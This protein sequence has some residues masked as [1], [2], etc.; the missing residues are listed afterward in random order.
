MFQTISS[1]TEGQM[2]LVGAGCRGSSAGFI[3][4][5]RP[6]A[7]AGGPLPAAQ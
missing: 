5:G 7:A 3:N 2:L 6:D 1:M 4:N